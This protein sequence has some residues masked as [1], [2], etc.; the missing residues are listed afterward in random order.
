MYLLVYDTVSNSFFIESNGKVNNDF[1][2]GIASH[3]LNEGTIPAFV[4]RDGTTAE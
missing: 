2:G 1:Y 3:F 4:W